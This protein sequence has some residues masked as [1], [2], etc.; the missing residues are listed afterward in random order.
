MRFATHHACIAHTH[1]VDG[2]ESACTIHAAMARPAAGACIMPWQEKSAA[3]QEFSIE[4]RNCSNKLK[5]CARVP[6]SRAIERCAGAPHGPW[7]RKPFPRNSFIYV[8]L[9]AK[10]LQNARQ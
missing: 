4:V 3:A 8:H 2:V 10:P 1:E 6:S 9:R 5:H 7:L